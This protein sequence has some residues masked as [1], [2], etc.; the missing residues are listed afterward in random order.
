MC[1]PW[2]KAKWDLGIFVN[3]SH[4]HTDFLSIPNCPESSCCLYLCCFSPPKGYTVYFP[5]DIS[6]PTKLLYFTTWSQNCLLLPEMFLTSN[7]SL[8]DIVP[9]SHLDRN[10]LGNEYRF[11]LLGCKFGSSSFWSVCFCAYGRSV[12][13]HN[14]T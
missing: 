12:I 13:W 6:A 3:F 7:V 2:S 1:I 8:V 5:W 14:F 10:E 11:Y 4:P 9:P